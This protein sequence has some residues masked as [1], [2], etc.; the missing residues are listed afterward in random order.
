MKNHIT[1]FPLHAGHHKTTIK[2]YTDESFKRFGS[3]PCLL[4][5]V[6]HGFAFRDVGQQHSYDAKSARSFSGSNQID[7]DYGNSH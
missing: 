1:L 7:I 4:Y 2:R 3:N 6:L 5:S